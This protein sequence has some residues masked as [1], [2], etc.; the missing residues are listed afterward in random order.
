MPRA[1]LHR[2]PGTTPEVETHL[3]PGEIITA[4]TLPAG[5]HSRSAY[6]KIRDRAACAFALVSAAVTL[7][8]APDRT[9][10]GCA[11]ALGGLA[12]KPWRATAA[13]RWLTGRHIDEGT[14][15]T[16]GKLALDGAVATPEQRF[17]I[18]LGAGTVA[19][20]ILT[21]VEGKDPV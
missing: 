11:I 12:A 10:T 1:D 21:A 2:L 15:V 7:T 14:A 5:D 13:E 20:A 6:V 18:A 9:V 8:R 17:K 3:R 16:A 4:I 19:R